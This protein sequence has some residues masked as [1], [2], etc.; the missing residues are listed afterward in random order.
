MSAD[1]N[2]YVVEHLLT[3]FA[4]GDLEAVEQV[5]APEF[6]N[7]DPPGLPGVG[8]DRAGVLTAM[9]STGRDIDVDFIHVFRVADGVV[10]R[11]GLAD[12]ASLLQQ[13]QADS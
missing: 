8:D 5:L 7:H 4:D 6:V 9:R 11:W 1:E 12:T 3:A 10:E 2:K 13:L